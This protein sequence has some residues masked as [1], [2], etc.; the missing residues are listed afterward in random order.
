LRDAN[1]CGN[2]HH[3]PENAREFQMLY[4]GCLLPSPLQ[5][6]AGWFKAADINATR[7]SRHYA[8]STS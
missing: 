8:G 1:G 2:E 4:H 7:L 6:I 3:T 5:E